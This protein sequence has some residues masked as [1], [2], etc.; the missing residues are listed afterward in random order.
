[1]QKV[2]KGEKEGKG[3]QRVRSE[4]RESCPEGEIPARVRIPAHS[5]MCENRSFRSE[6]WA[7]EKTE[8][9]KKGKR[10]K[11]RCAELARHTVAMGNQGGGGRRMEI[12]AKGCLAM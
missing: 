10:R 6:S 11:A 7:A 5:G 2:G 12:R 1:M 9:G 4:R 8:K 3:E